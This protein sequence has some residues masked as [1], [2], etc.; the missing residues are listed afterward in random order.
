MN[1]EVQQVINRMNMEYE[2]YKIRQRIELLDGLG[3]VRRVNVNGE[4]RLE[5][6]QLTDEEFAELE[7]AQERLD[8][9]SPEK[10]HSAPRVDY[11]KYRSGKG[12]VTTF[13]LFGILILVVSF[14]IGIV[15]G[16]HEVIEGNG[17]VHKEF[18]LALA[19]VYWGVGFVSCSA[20][21]AFANIID[22]LN[23]QTSLLRAMVNKK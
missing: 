15:L 14:I 11:E 1:Q 9:I 10:P 13:T 12:L 2:G 6:P 17:Y 8:S 22:N 5:Y 19:M 18:D 16:K 3:L 23:R 20:M 4:I 21:L 7:K